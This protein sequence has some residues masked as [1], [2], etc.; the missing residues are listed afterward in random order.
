MYSIF[1]GSKKPGNYARFWSVARQK[2]ASGK[3]DLV[4][5]QWGQSGMLALPKQIPLVV[6]FRGDD[7]EG[8]IGPNGKHTNSGRILRLISRTVAMVADEIILVSEALARHIHRQSYHIIPSGIDLDLFKPGSR[9][10]ARQ[11]LGLSPDRCYV[12]FAGAAAN[13]RKRIDLARNAIQHVSEQ[14]DVELIVASNVNHDE[15]PLYMNASNALLL[16]SLHEGSPNVVKEAI[17]CNL[18]IVSTNVGDVWERIGNLPGCYV[19]PDDQPETI[20]CC[21]Q[22]ALQQTNRPAIRQSVQS[23]DEK[24]LTNKVLE[25]YEKALH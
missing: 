21:L 10:E 16:T 22:K 4:H 8:I 23:L 2:I 1:R 9:D 19:C 3:Y 12:L 11:H 25:V 6:T 18:P 15:I 17:A 5:A 20:A 7:L 13:P 24:N 14:F